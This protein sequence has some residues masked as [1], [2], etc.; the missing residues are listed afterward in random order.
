MLNN[1]NQYSFSKE[2]AMLN[3]NCYTKVY[4]DNRIVSNKRC[5][6]VIEL[7]KVDSFHSQVK[8]GIIQVW[9]LLQPKRRF[10]K[11]TN[12]SMCVVLH[13]VTLHHP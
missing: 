4:D 8:V 9:S 2:S 10:F 1:F 11:E 3:S 12:V 5:Y 13:S 7:F 6:Q